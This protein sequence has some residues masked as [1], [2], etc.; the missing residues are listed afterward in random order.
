MKKIYDS[1]AMGILAVN[2]LKDLIHTERN[3]ERREALEGVRYAYYY[4]IDN[5]IKQFGVSHQDVEN[6]LVELGHTYREADEIATEYEKWACH[7]VKINE[8]G[9]NT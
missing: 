4:L 2:E 5:M 6:A 1:V 3:G 8:R 9:D 7:V